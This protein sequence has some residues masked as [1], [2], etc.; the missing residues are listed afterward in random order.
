MAPPR[1]IRTPGQP[2]T[3][4]LA[5]AL[6]KSERKHRDN[7]RPGPLVIAVS[8]GADSLAL[9]FA[10]NAVKHTIEREVLVAHFS[11]GIRKTAERREAAL[12]K[13]IAKELGL[14]I[15]HERTNAVPSEAA[16]REARYAFLARANQSTQAAAVVTAHT[17]D[18][19]A[20]TLLLR[21]TRGSG[22]RGA[23]AIREFSI[24]KVEGS[25]LTL[26]RPLLSNLRAETVATC[27]E[28]G[29]TPAAD[30]TNRSLRYARNRIRHR[31]L[32]ELEEVNPAVRQALSRF[33]AAAQVDNDFL[34]EM[35]SDAIEGVEERSLG[36]VAWPT[37][38]LRY[39]PTPLLV[40]VLQRGWAAV[41][42]EGAT[43]SQQHIAAAIDLVHRTEG[44]SLDLGNGV[45]LVIEQNRVAL[46]SHTGPPTLPWTRLAI[47]GSTTVHD[48]VIDI[49]VTEHKTAWDGDPWHA[50][51][52]LRELGEPAIVRSREP[53]DRIQLSEHLETVSLQNLLVNVKMPRTIRD[54]LPLIVGAYGIA[55]VAGVRIASWAKA[56]DK[57]SRVCDVRVRRVEG[58]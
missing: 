56:T 52:D 12:V 13:R 20:E 27:G 11:H 14:T 57:T 46:T 10:A 58:Q 6:L 41:N 4:K 31:V 47:P 45:R 25:S 51:I 32:R 35:T 21:L 26:L 49:A 33:A 23:G 44:G 43:L 8:G 5:R 3:D 39:L 18:D 50:V 28:H 1:I 36:I 19:Q 37:A 7:L 42:G 53:G 15:I 34:D 29:V 38:V 22:L 16:A 54:S 17:L 40:R 9:L 30:G 55:W 2:A 24:R 48:W